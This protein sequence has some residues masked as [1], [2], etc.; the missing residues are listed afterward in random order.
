MS[1]KLSRADYLIRISV[2]I[3]AA[4][5]PL[6]CLLYYG[7]LPSISSYW[8]TDLQPLFIIANVVTAYYLYSIN[9]W[10]KSA[11]LLLLLTAFSIELYPTLHNIIA[12]SFFIVNII[13]M[14]QSGY[15]KWC[16]Y[17]YLTSLIV[18]PWSMTFA[19][20]IAISSLCLYHLLLLRKLYNIV[21]KD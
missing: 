21:K 14:I 6:I 15:F 16:I 5:S 18:L 10:K 8:K 7:Y 20:I 9:N 4:T 17:P 3:I 11:M 19:E 12:I 2:I 13:P 1:F